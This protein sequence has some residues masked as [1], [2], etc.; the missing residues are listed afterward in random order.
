MK[1][2]VYMLLGLILLVL[3]YDISYAQLG[4]KQPEGVGVQVGTTSAET[5]IKVIV[6]G[7]VTLFFTVGA[8]AVLI[9][10]IWG[11]VSFILSGGDKERVASARRKITWTLIGFVL[12][13]LSF[14]II[15]SIGLLV[16]FNPLGPLRIPSFTQRT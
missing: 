4:V 10:F 14:V 2:L 7:I 15:Q 9:M 6:E 16:G 5:L 3:P 8:I 1:I 12:L 11:A 13:A